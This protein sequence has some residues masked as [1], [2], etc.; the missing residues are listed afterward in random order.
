MIM[1]TALTKA[2]TMHTF[3]PTAIFMDQHL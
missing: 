2:L 3:T 1:R